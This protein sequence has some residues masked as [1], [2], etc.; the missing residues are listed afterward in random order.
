MK[1]L[2][3]LTD[4]ELDEELLR[5]ITEADHI[6]EEKMRRRETKNTPGTGE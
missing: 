5:A 2:K 1:R 6:R 3:T 4:A